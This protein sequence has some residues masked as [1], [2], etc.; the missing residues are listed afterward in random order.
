MCRVVSASRVVVWRSLACVACARIRRSWKRS[1]RTI[2]RKNIAYNY[3]SI[4]IGWVLYIVVN[5]SDE[6]VIFNTT[7]LPR[8]C[9]CC[10]EGRAGRGSRNSTLT[11][12]VR[13]YF[14]RCKIYSH[15]AIYL[16]NGVNFLFCKKGSMLDRRAFFKNSRYYFTTTKSAMVWYG[17]GF[18]G[19][20]RKSSE[21]PAYKPLCQSSIFL[22]LFFT[23]KKLYIRIYY[24]L[25]RWEIL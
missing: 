24:V 14:L 7:A 25:K 8:S 6:C 21:K 4:T 19:E 5:R 20:G 15:V 10:V 12:L 22:S 18:G 16:C 3:M 2:E 9:A 13:I 1:L 17:I 23:L 11:L